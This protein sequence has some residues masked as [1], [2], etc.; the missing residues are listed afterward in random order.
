MC[1]PKK[2]FTVLTVAQPVMYREILVVE[3]KG[4]HA[5]LGGVCCCT[6]GAWGVS[7]SLSFSSLI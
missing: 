4:D 2:S 1:W 7:T 3:E 5:A 6:G